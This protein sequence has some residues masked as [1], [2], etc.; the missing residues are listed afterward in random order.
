VDNL[1]RVG[2]DLA[3]VNLDKNDFAQG[4]TILNLYMTYGGTNCKYRFPV[5]ERSC[6]NRD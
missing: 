3:N 5:V 6:A 2:G 4:V 1:S